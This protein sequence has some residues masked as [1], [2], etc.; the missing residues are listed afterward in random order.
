MSVGRDQGLPIHNDHTVVEGKALE[1]S[2]WNSMHFNDTLC[3]HQC[4][5]PTLSAN[6]SWPQL[7]LMPPCLVLYYEDQGCNFTVSVSALPVHEP[8]GGC[9]FAVSLFR[10]PVYEP[11][12]VLENLQNLQR[13]ICGNQSLLI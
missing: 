2:T 7:S 5:A 8:L 9:N 6:I 11:L 13:K 4:S 3:K 1:F 12:R 10:L